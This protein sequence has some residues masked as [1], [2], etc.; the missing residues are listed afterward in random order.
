MLAG[1]AST[2]EKR[3]LDSFTSDIRQP[4]EEPPAAGREAEDATT[5]TFED[6]M[7]VGVAHRVSP[8]QEQ[9]SAPQ[10]RKCRGV[11]AAGQARGAV[12]EGLQ[13]GRAGRAQQR[14]LAVLVAQDDPLDQYIVAH[15]GEL[16]GRPHESAI[17]DNGNAHVLEPHL[18]CAAFEMALDPTSDEAYFGPGFVASVRPCS[19]GTEL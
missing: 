8:A 4:D 7:A 1:L 14:S 6:G 2:N 16:F 15:P 9:P 11:D 3:P 13:A 19:T 10:E 17:I 18:A 12:A 5:Y